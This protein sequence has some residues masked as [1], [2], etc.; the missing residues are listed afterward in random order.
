MARP[1]Q[2]GCQYFP[3]DCDFF[4]DRKVRLLR[5]QYGA[6]A[7]AVLIRLWCAIYAGTGWYIHLDADE[8]ALMAESMGGGFSVQYIGDVIRASC[9]RGLFDKAIFTKC[10]VLT[11]EGIQ[12]R[13]LSIKSRKEK[14]PIIKEYWVL[15]ESYFEGENA[16]LLLKL[17][18]YS[19]SAEKT[20]VNVTETPVNDAITPQSKVKKSKAKKSKEAAAKTQRGLDSA[21]RPQH[22]PSEPYPADERIADRFRSLSG[23][24][25]DLLTALYAFDAM[26]REIKKPLTLTGADRL[27]SKLRR[28]ASEAN[29]Q[30]SSAY[31]IQ[32]LDESTANSW[33]GVFPLKPGQFHDSSPA[34]SV[35]IGQ[36]VDRPRMIAEGEDITAY[37]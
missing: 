7:E 21:A 16:A 12:K 9:E 3:L 36:A 11:G 19:V 20:A 35:H 24:D 32:V 18:F 15:P 6:K 14:I 33:Q 29:V 2:A 8:I 31:M 10:Q 34:A 30:N 28:L 23:E 17:Q 4:N 5:A 25:H 37:L 22:E 27:C 13:Y 26:R 1:A